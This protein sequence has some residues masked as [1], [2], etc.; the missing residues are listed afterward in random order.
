MG[1]LYVTQPS[2]VNDQVEFSFF[3]NKSPDGRLLEL[4]RAGGAAGL[5]KVSS[6][7]YLKR[8]RI[9]RAVALCKDPEQKF[10]Q[11]QAAEKFSSLTRRS[12]ASSKEFSLL[13][14]SG[15]I[16]RFQESLAVRLSDQLPELQGSASFQALEALDGRSR[17][18]KRLKGTGSYCQAARGS[19]GAMRLRKGIPRPFRVLYSNV[20]LLD[21]PGT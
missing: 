21:F 12:G 19:S 20:Q 14:Q 10:L 3:F 8:K 1:L 15:I 18:W 11:L 5:I 7:T 17:G 9:L 2:H 4:G 13:F 6:K 16:L